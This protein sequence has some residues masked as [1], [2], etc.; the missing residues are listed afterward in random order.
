MTRATNPTGSMLLDRSAAQPGSI[1]KSVFEKKTASSTA[2]TGQGTV[3]PNYLRECREDNPEP[4]P[5]DEQSKSVVL[6]NCKITTPPEDLVVDQPFEMSVETKS[7]NGA[8]SGQVTFRLFCTIPDPAGGPPKCEDQSLSFSG[9]D[10]D[11][12]AKASGKLISPKKP[13]PA[14]TKLQY[15]VVAEHLDAKEKCESPKV[16]VESGKPPKPLAVW[17]L[18]A[19]HFGFDSSFILPSAAAKIADFKAEIA[20]HPGAALAVFGH[21]DP[22]GED[23][24][25]KGLSG[26]RAFAVWCLLAKDPTGWTQLASADKWDLR[27]TQTMLSHLKDKA[28]SAP[29]YGGSIDGKTGPKT[30]SAIKAFRA[31]HSLGNGTALDA[32]SKEALY[33]AYMESVCEVTCKPE[34]FVGDP[35]DTKRQWACVGCSEFNPVLVF[36]KSD[37]AKFRNASDKTERN[38]KN[39]PNR[40]ATVFLFPPGAKGPGN[41]EFPCP[42][43]SEGV[44]ACRKQLFEDADKRRNPSDAERTWEKDKDTFAC[45]FYADVGKSEGVGDIVPPSKRGAKAT[46]ITRRFFDFCLPR[47]PYLHDGID[48][49]AG[50]WAIFGDDISQSAIEKLRTGAKAGSLPLPAFRI[51]EDLTGDSPAAYSTNTIHVSRKLVE[52]AE[53]SQKNRW[54]LFTA[55]LQEFGHHV[56]HLLRQI[57]SGTEGEKQGDE[58]ARFAADFIHFNELIEADFEFG[59]VEYSDSRQVRMEMQAHAFGREERCKHLLNIKD[60]DDHG[61]LTLPDGSKVQVEFFTF[62]GAGAAH[63]TITKA[64]A[65]AVG[66]PYDH[67]LDEGCA[68]PDVPCDDENS[69]ET[70]YATTWRNLD[71]PGTL[72]YRSHHG[73]LQYYHS[74]CPTGSPSNR[75]V[76]QKIMEQLE[77]WYGKA[78]LNEHKNGLFHLGKMLHTIQD[79]FCGSHAF[80]AKSAEVQPGPLLV[81][82][83]DILSFQDYNKQDEKKHSTAD[84]I[85][86]RG[87]AEAIEASKKIMTFY[88]E[89]VPFFPEVDAYLDLHVFTIPAHRLD[90]VSGEIRAEYKKDPPKK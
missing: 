46:G 13:V 67:R 4:T 78:R 11:G 83:W 61:E 63:E 56:E 9:K 42:Q 73:D 40:R 30:E 12:L 3:N 47:L 32:K 68:W 84:Q 50:I 89:N 76:K 80:R 69:V 15:H 85:G 27:T 75:K 23:D 51:A 53:S 44:S 38:A 65:E 35:K 25:N 18:G 90:D 88:K 59:D 36:G 43:W 29:Y 10:V 1:D 6:G 19:V 82:E 87:Y 57:F 8:P 33:K 48:F 7:S 70:C 64:A 16:E 31:D 2:S 60:G 5:T 49:D 77:Y 28:A 39:A 55:I 22:V 37:D 86:T 45:R 71:K 41:V 26:R 52:S 24:A 74:M 54:V 58:G 17:S 14:G 79:S 21:A 62:R 20:K 81:K 66:I 34:D 72:A